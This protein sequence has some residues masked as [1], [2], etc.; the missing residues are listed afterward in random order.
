MV[1]DGRE[2]SWD[3][4][5]GSDERGWVVTVDGPEV[6]RGG[7]LEEAVT[8]EVGVVLNHTEGVIA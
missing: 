4:Q 8:A 5:G 3:Y 6:W 7:V 1:A 2:V